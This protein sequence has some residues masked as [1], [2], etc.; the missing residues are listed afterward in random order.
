MK[1]E[2]LI[3]VPAAMLAIGLCSATVAQTAEPQS[4]TGTVQ[5]ANSQLP[6]GQPTPQP[7]P[8]PTLPSPIAPTNPVMPPPGST[9]T[10]PAKSHSKPAA[11]STVT[12]LMTF[13]YRPWHG[14]ITLD[15]LANGN[16]PARFVVAT[17]L[18]MS[19][20][21]PEDAIRLQLTTSTTKA[22]VAVLDASADVPTASI[23]KL[24][25]GSGF[26]HDI[27]VAQVNLISLLTHEPAPDAPTC[28]LGTSWLSDYRVTLNFDTHTITLD[29]KTSPFPKPTGSII[30]FKLNNGRPVVKV[31]VAGGGT[32][33]AIVDTSE[34]GTLIPRDI[35]LKLKS[36]KADKNTPKTGTDVGSGK[37]ARMVLPKIAVGK[38]ELKNIMV[39]YYGAAAPNAADKT[40]AVIGLDFLRRFRVSINYAKQQMELYAPPAPEAAPGNPVQPVKRPGT[41]GFGPFGQG[42]LGT[43]PSGTNPSGNYPPG[44]NQPGTIPH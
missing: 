31:T 38:A 32:F 30:P 40:L 13:T 15:G 8:Q 39:A 12:T 28:W 24:R 19:T 26:L 23:S 36:K 37:M 42:Q 1:R 7:T 6:I 11:K 22:H 21:S 41:A 4:G 17:G 20:V 2:A 18:N 14:L 44:T 5:P 16:N 29:T 3:G 25:L 10:K 33:D 34:M 27:N 43:N 35:A 9:N